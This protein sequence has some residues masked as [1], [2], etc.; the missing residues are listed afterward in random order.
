MCTK[1]SKER[2]FPTDSS[3]T[4]V[5]DG[6]L[7]CKEFSVRLF[8]GLKF[9]EVVVI[10]HNQDDH[11]GLVRSCYATFVKLW[12]ANKDNARWCP[13]ANVCQREA[14]STAPSFSLRSLRHHVQYACLFWSGLV[15]LFPLVTSSSS[16][17]PPRPK[18]IG[19][20]IA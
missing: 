3:G 10:Y 9:E 6:C 17:W 19:I 11:G 14:L 16:A 8:P 4:A 20:G 12:F 5:G 13:S 18:A 15:G 1:S 7:V 2:D